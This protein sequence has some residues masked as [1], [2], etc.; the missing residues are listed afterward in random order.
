MHRH[1]VQ[2]GRTLH[3]ATFILVL[4]LPLLVAACGQGNGGGTGY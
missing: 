4:I 1:Q 2:L 3:V